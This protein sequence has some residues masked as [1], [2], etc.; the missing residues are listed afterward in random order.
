MADTQQAP[1]QQPAG[2]QPPIMPDGSIAEAQEALLGLLEPEEE[3]PEAEEAKPTEEEESNEESQDESLEE[4]P[5]ESSEEEEGEELDDDEEADEDEETEEPE[6][7]VTLYTVKVNGEDTEV[8]EDEL[9]R[10]YSRHSDYT[11]KTQELAEERRTI[12]ASQAQYQS[13][14]AALQ[15]ERQQYA[16][17]LSEVIQSSMAGLEQY[18]NIDWET[19]KTDDPIE[20]I[21][22]RDEY[23]EI[24]ERVRQNQYQVQ[25]VQQQQ[26]AE[27]QEVK[28]RV[29]REEHGKLVAAVPEWGEPATQKKLATDL[30]TYAVDQGY[31][32]E[33]IS[34]LIDHRS[35]IVLMKAQKYDDLQKADV[36]SKKVKNKPKV[37]RSGTGTKKTQEGKSQRKAQMKRL[38]GTGHIDDASALLADFIDM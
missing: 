29:L 32:P 12:E 34:G 19:L 37:V 36:K 20:Y 27:M 26:E 6:E 33:E 3:K 23:R 11:K 22:K 7:E 13:E 4:E 15:Q 18:S 30:R 5:D 35:L 17:A 2:L 21:T 38:R 10:G 9:I 24:Q 31:T 25:Q 1:Q 16:E 28:K 14:L 8:T